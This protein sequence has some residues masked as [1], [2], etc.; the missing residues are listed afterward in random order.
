MCGLLPRT[1]KNKK[2]PIIFPGVNCNAP[3]P[4]KGR[5]LLVL[6]HLLVGCTDGPRFCCCSAKTLRG[7]VVFGKF[8]VQGTV[9]TPGLRLVQPQL[10]A[11]APLLNPHLLNPSPHT[12]KHTGLSCQ[13]ANLRNCVSVRVWVRTQLPPGRQ[14]TAQHSRSGS[15]APRCGGHH[16]P[17]HPNQ[18]CPGLRQRAHGS[19]GVACW[20]RGAGME[21]GW[22]DD[23]TCPLQ[24][25]YSTKQSVKSKLVKQTTTAQL[26][27]AAFN[28][29]I[30]L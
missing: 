2:H 16:H 13:A 6:V 21:N 24:Q 27:S 26:K 9:Q 11:A 12:H 22:G 19:T 5:G 23:L 10:A 30:L 29:S 3:P 17:K 14:D 8:R 7:P 25:L 18:S 4:R 1:S 15:S 28:S 20:G